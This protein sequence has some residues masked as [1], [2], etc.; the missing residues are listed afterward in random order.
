M[1]TLDTNTI[2]YY[3]KGKPDVVSFIEEV[4]QRHT[5]LFISTVTEIELFGFPTLTTNEAEQIDEL[6]Q[7][8]SVISVDSRLARVAGLLRRTCRLPLADSAI[9]TTALL[10]GSTLATRNV[11]DFLK[12]PNLRVQKV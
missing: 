5:S 6:V 7:T 8:V 10:T 11:R 1:Y 4:L 12:I 2:I 9:A 3:V